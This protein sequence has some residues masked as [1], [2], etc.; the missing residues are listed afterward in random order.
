[1]NSSMEI[2]EKEILIA[3]YNSASDECGGV[4]L[5]GRR[6]ADATSPHI[7]IPGRRCD[8]ADYRLL[9]VM[10]ARCH[11][12]SGGLPPKSQRN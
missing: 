8:G 5:G 12:A 6:N 3:F 2:A 1:M 4:I 9:L 10:L 7:W 11:L